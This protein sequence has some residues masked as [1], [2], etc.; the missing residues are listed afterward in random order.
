ML[1]IVE[2]GTCDADSVAL[3]AAL[4]VAV[5]DDV[6]AEEVFDRVADGGLAVF[7]EVTVTLSLRL[8]DF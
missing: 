5:A 2:V 3:W 4:A 6:P 1:L 7:V 8:A